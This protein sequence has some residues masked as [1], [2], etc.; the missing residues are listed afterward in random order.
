MKMKN[1]IKEYLAAMTL[2]LLAV[3]I[4]FVVTYGV[5]MIAFWIL[6]SLGAI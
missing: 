4:W 6:S 2:A 1:E 5:L 3:L